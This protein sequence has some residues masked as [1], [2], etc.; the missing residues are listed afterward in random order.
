MTLW[1]IGLQVFALDARKTYLVY[2]TL[3]IVP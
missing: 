1:K 2:A 3:Q